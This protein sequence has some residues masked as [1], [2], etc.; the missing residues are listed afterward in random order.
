MLRPR[1]LRISE[2][3][4]E[5]A[6]S[7]GRKSSEQGFFVS[8]CGRDRRKTAEEPTGQVGQPLPRAL[9]LTSRSHSGLYDNIP[10]FSVRKKGYSDVLEGV[11]ESL[12]TLVEQV[13]DDRAELISLIQQKFAP[14]GRTGDAQRRLEAGVPEGLPLE[15][16]PSSREP[17]ARDIKVGVI[18]AE[19]GKGIHVE[20][21][22]MKAI[23][24]GTLSPETVQKV[25][26][27]L[28]SLIDD[29][30]RGNVEVTSL[31]HRVLATNSDVA[32]RHE[33]A[34]GRKN[35][36]EVSEV[37]PAVSFP[38]QDKGLP[39][40]S[41]QTGTRDRE[42]PGL[43]TPFV[44][45]LVVNRASGVIIED[46][47]QRTDEGI[48]ARG[49]R[50]VYA[51]DSV[52]Q[53]GVRY[54]ENGTKIPSE[55]PN[56]KSSPGKCDISRLGQDIQSLMNEI[57][58]GYQRIR[59]VVEEACHTDCQ[60]L[61]PQLQTQTNGETAT[62]S[63]NTN[64]FSKG[65]E[66]KSAKSL[67]EGIDRSYIGEETPGLTNQTP[68]KTSQAEFPQQGRKWEDHPDTELHEQKCE[69]T[70][71]PKLTPLPPRTEV[72][73]RE[74][75]T[76][77]D[78]EKPS[79][80][81]TPMEDVSSKATVVRMSAKLSVSTDRRSVGS[82]T[83]AAFSPGNQAYEQSPSADKIQS[84]DGS[85]RVSSKQVATMTELGEERASLKPSKISLMITTCSTKWQ[86]TKQGILASLRGR[87]CSFLP[88]P[89]AGT[90]S[91]P[92]DTPDGSK[93][94]S[95]E[96]EKY[97]TVS[98]GSPVPSPSKVSAAK[99]GR[100]CNCLSH[101]A[102]TRIS[103]ESEESVAS[104]QETRENI[105]SDVP[106]PVSTDSEKGRESLG[107]MPDGV[108]DRNS[109]S[110]ARNP[111]RKSSSASRGG[112]TLGMKAPKNAS[113][114]SEGRDSRL[115]RSSL[116]ESPAVQM[117]LGDFNPSEALTTGTTVP[118]S[119]EESTENART[120]SEIRPEQP[121][122]EAELQDTHQEGSEMPEELVQFRAGPPDDQVGQSRQS[123]SS[124]RESKETRAILASPI[125]YVIETETADL[126]PALDFDSDPAPSLSPDPVTSLGRTSRSSRSQSSPTELLAVR[127]SLEG[128]RVPSPSFLAPPGRSSIVLRESD[129][130]GKRF[131]IELTSQR[132]SWTSEGRS[133]SRLQR[134]E[135]Q[136]DGGGRRMDELAGEKEADSLKAEVVLRHSTRSNRASQTGD[137]VE[138]V[139]SPSDGINTTTITVSH[140]EHSITNV[141]TA[142]PPACSEPQ[143]LETPPVEKQSARRL[144]RCP[145]RAPFRAR[146]TQDSQAC[147]TVEDERQDVCA[148]SSQRPRHP[149]KA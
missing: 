147:E 145:H 98:A 31:L 69:I 2:P 99:F 118:S 130:T 12:R 79:A 112:Q 82:S 3:D 83:E 4:L 22:I 39:F 8:C 53:R 96:P 66:A 36:E 60:R 122:N 62:D 46:T 1:P 127:K 61:S 133:E 93:D 34:P 109:I 28:R 63:Q 131:S 37:V 121:D 67:S 125:P 11:R 15:D 10:P 49:S 85:R 7:L 103:T 100:G 18:P 111:V 128:R 138:P 119:I 143:S 24:R 106:M 14:Y 110:M 88:A 78:V 134:L 45:S 89:S 136:P 92:T 146:R 68:D 42:S 129:A 80:T 120:T 48:G 41:G 20:D 139:S 55:E 141:S 144:P 90:S 23:G 56:D 58:S 6:K 116:E 26:E 51:A 95:K 16:L 5:Q 25:K 124:L 107:S 104:R 115:N 84:S 29:V 113:L 76:M 38:G 72:D 17:Y 77:S 54:Q 65:E 117:L 47:P 105:F 71:E 87:G 142:L 70:W 19:S 73:A 33:S 101:E 91:A 13:Y 59:V 132:S 30:Q 44:P 102:S 57:R 75:L 97:E 81:V 148:P 50:S 74:C 114:E 43:E 27:S 149:R 140:H 94:N 35:V 32:V 21:R 123:S 108:L 40:S 9:S 135:P 52:E 64:D 86:D 126:S 137:P